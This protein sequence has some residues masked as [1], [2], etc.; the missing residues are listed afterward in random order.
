[1]FCNP[2]V[3]LLFAEFA[4]PPLRRAL[5]KKASAFAPTTQGPYR[6]SPVPAE[7]SVEDDTLVTYA[8]A[9]RRYRGLRRTVN[10]LFASLPLSMLPWLIL[11]PPADA[12]AYDVPV[13]AGAMAVGWL[14]SYLIF[15][16]RLARFRCPACCARF[17]K[18]GD[19]KFRECHGCHLRKFGLMPEARSDAAPARFDP[20]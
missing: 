2:A 7:S 11:P 3:V 6:D 9:W 13:A 17:E 16:V 10:L 19:W 1:M 18:G 4:V 15:V 20:R 14:V 5:T 8:A 12:R